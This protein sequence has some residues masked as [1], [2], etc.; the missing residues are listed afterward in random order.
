M[1]FVE[2]FCIRVHEEDWAVVFFP[3]PFLSVWLSGL[4]WFLKMNCLLFLHVR[5]ELSVS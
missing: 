2:N 3:V 5:M 1:I 4:C